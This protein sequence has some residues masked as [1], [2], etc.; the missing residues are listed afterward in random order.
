MDHMS[1]CV[2]IGPKMGFLSVFSSL[3]HQI[4]LILHIHAHFYSFELLLQQNWL[5]KIFLI[6]FVK[7]EI[8]IE[9]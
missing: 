2:Q 5:I 1:I 6:V 9:K 3:N 7:S 8:Q 4:R